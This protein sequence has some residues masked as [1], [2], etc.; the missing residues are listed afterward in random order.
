MN[1]KRLGDKKVVPAEAGIC[2]GGGA[3]AAVDHSIMHSDREG[4]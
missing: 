3:D 4:T 1:T 2:G